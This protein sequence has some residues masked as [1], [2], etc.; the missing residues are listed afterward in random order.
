[1]VTLLRDGFGFDP[2][3]RDITFAL[4]VQDSEVEWTLGMALVLNSHPPTHAA[5]SLSTPEQE[6]CDATVELRDESNGSNPLPQKD[7]T[8]NAT[9]PLASRD[10]VVLSTRL[11]LRRVAQFIETISALD[12]MHTI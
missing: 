2:H 6:V 12:Y 8:Q 5:E 1:M 4:D 11:I 7:E 9:D 10:K 3:A